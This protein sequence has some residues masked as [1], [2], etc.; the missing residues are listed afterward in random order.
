MNKNFSHY[1]KISPNGN[2]THVRYRNK[3]PPQRIVLPV[4]ENLMKTNTALRAVKTQHITTIQF[5]STVKKKEKAN[6][7]PSYRFAAIKK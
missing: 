2:F 1:E 7:S 4:R 3:T 6:N 5:L